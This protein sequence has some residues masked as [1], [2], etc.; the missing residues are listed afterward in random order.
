MLRARPRAPRRACE[1]PTRP[2]TNAREAPGPAHTRGN[3]PGLQSAR[4]NTD[5]L[6]FLSGITRPGRHSVLR[7]RPHAPRQACEAPTRPGTNARE[8]PR[9]TRRPNHPA[10]DTEN[11]RAR[12]HPR[13]PTRTRLKPHANETGPASITPSPGAQQNSPVDKKPL[14]HHRERTEGAGPQA[15]T[16]TLDGKPTQCTTREPGTHHGTTRD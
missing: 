14:K 2:G 10:R 15:R 12:A 6:G 11:H 13:H 3:H 7:A 5:A 9:P 8:V 16:R 1:T 4:T